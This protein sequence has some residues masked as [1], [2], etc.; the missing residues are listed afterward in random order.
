MI[1]L[2][3]LQLAVPER[4]N[5]ALMPVELDISF[6]AL[7][8][9]GWVTSLTNPPVGYSQESFSRTYS[10]VDALGF[11]MR[12]CSTTLNSIHPKQNLTRP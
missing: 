7:Q 4:F 9:T 12:G 10:D 3:N 5:H 1:E 11:A 6:N 2:E 8:G